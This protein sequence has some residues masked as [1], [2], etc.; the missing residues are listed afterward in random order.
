MF[1][2][3]K[4]P[5]IRT[6]REYFS[7]VSMTVPKYTPNWQE[8]TRQLKSKLCFW[9]RSLFTNASFLSSN[10][11]HEQC[12]NRNIPSAFM[13]IIR[14]GLDK[15]DMAFSILPRKDEGQLKLEKLKIHFPRFWK[16]FIRPKD[17]FNQEYIYIPKVPSNQ[18]IVLPSD[19]YTH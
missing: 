6:M 10:A 8:C 7:H 9:V 2:F 16:I 3:S 11:F 17:H 5:T 14:P 12:N 4:S 1:M 13:L 18:S 15:P 19:F